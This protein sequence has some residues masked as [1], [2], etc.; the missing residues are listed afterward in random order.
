MQRIIL[1]LFSTLLSSAGF[2]QHRDMAILPLPKSIILQK[3]SL[4]INPVI[5]IDLPGDINVLPVKDILNETLLDNGII[6]KI[7]YPA[8]TAPKDP[9]TVFH[10][11]HDTTLHKKGAYTIN[12]NETIHIGYYDYEGFVNSLQT[13][14]QIL[15]Q[16]NVKKTCS[17]PKFALE[18]YPQFSYRG[19]HLDVS[20][21]FFNVPFVKKYISWLSLHKLN[22]FHW[23]LTDDQGWRIPIKGWEKLTSTGAYRNETLI[24]HFRDTPVRYDGTRYG[25]FYTISQIKEVIQ[26]AKERAVDIIPEIDIPG[27]SRAAIAAYPFLST[28]P[29]TTFPV[30]TTWGFFNRANNVLSPNQY[31]FRFLKE[32]FEQVAALFPGKYV[33]IGGDECSKMWWKKSTESQQFI[34]EN[35]LQ[36]ENGL[37]TYFI[38][39]VGKILQAKSKYIIG[40]DEILEGESDQG[41]LVMSW[42][43]E[44]GGIEAAK[45]NMQVIM[46]PGQP[47]YFD[48]YQTQ[49]KNDSL[50]IHGY[51][52]LDA[53]YNYYPIPK[54]LDSMS[55]GYSIAGAQANV[56]TEYMAS[57]AKVE[58]MIF[59]R[60]A[61]LSE[62]VWTA[63]KQK[64][65]KAFLN[66]LEKVLVP[67][68]KKQKINYCRSYK[69]W[70]VNSP[71]IK[72]Q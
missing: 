39:Y 43:G 35:H 44:K 61:A 27:H 18:D 21:H 15:Q 36:H 72:R 45:K 19:M 60:M 52:P 16:V 14:R 2:A 63:P 29:D 17:I 38:N 32:V 50:A 13:F 30:G 25:G 62:A 3:G 70:N 59:P 47:L 69:V 49:D 42:R 9:H 4:S 37:Q 20:R 34:K 71:A 58:Y 24:G 41:T 12:T 5:A 56:W 67:L 7:I 11:I 23:H 51:N 10:F 64:D 26:Y 8:R 54:V 1:I 65:Y 33:H 57:E 46:T 53:V 48:H 40:W 66:R 22:T 55:L 68:Y 31:T 28:E 6:R